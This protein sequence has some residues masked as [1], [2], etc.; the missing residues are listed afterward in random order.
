MVQ[1]LSKI[2]FIFAASTRSAKQI[3]QN[4]RHMSIPKARITIKPLLATTNLIFE[5]LMCDIKP[6]IKILKM[7]GI[8]AFKDQA[9]ST[10]ESCVRHDKSM[11]R[12]IRSYGAL[13]LGHSV[14]MMIFE[15][16]L[17]LEMHYKGALSRKS[18]SVCTTP[19]YHFPKV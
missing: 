2:D 1:P 15:L 12:R 8:S 16:G 17:K 4:Y 14:M 9:D 3:S 7:H 13:Q 11:L 10:F 5:N 6:V 19:P 18:T